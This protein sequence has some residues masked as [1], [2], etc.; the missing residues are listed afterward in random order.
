MKGKSF[1]TIKEKSPL[2]SNRSSVVQETFSPKMALDSKN[3]RMK[4]VDI[5]ELKVQK[6]QNSSTF[7]GS[8][9]AEEKLRDIS[10][11]NDDKNFSFSPEY[12]PEENFIA[13]IK[14][15]PD[16]MKMKDSEEQ[17]HEKNARNHKNSD[18]ESPKS[19]FRFFTETFKNPKPF[20]SHSSHFFNYDGDS[21]PERQSPIRQFKYDA[22]LGELKNP[23]FL[24]NLINIDD[25]ICVPEI[26]NL[27][28]GSGFRRF[29]SAHGSLS[30]TLKKKNS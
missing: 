3:G 21:S 26:A 18:S 15:G 20:I 12:K 27:P 7:A 17:E 10:L 28:G 8:D 14:F 16:K 24:L 30:E 5:D 13:D 23:E 29:D 11:L 25:N 1:D 9:N 4:H 22:F 19:L 6:Q 2:E